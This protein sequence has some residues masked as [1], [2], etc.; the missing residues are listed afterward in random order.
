M[1][2]A[3][4][5]HRMHR[6]S[7]KVLKNK[8]SDSEL[9]IIG[10]T[11]NKPS[12]HSSVE[13]NPHTNQTKEDHK[14][15]DIEESD[16]IEE[17]ELTRIELLYQ[18]AELR[19]PTFYYQALTLDAEK[20][21]LQERADQ[22]QH[23]LEIELRIK[24]RKLASR[25]YGWTDVP[26]NLPI[27]QPDQMNLND[28]WGALKSC[29][30]HEFALQDPSVSKDFFNSLREMMV[31]DDLETMQHQWGSEYQVQDYFNDYPSVKH[32]F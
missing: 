13:I 5:P 4:K 24:S 32:V 10:K 16:E 18:A 20:R 2:L 29:S 27:M 14:E 22:L 23:R 11:N 6:P 1:A 30:D 7:P 25:Y 3:I 12:A 28:M 9:V 8:D 19:D 31:Y 26:W 21:A 17:I 15:E